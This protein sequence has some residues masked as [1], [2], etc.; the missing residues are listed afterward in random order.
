MYLFPS[1][2]SSDPRSPCGTSGQRHVV[3]GT[4]PS[5]DYRYVFPHKR[6]YETHILLVLD[7]SQAP[8]TEGV[9]GRHRPHPFPNLP[10]TRRSNSLRPSVRGPSVSNPRLGGPSVPDL[11]PR[12]SI[13]LRLSSRGSIRLRPSPGGLYVSDPRP[14]GPSISDPQ[15]VEGCDT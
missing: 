12:G 11:R 13:R 14:G 10:S 15:E 3:A 7:L 9:T 1:P 2:S 4:I 6:R 8:C 5:R